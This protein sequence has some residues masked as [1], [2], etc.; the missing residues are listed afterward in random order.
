MAGKYQAAAPHIALAAASH[1][2]DT[3]GARVLLAQ[4]GIIQSFIKFINLRYISPIPFTLLN[5][6]GF[7]TI[8]TIFSLIRREATNVFKLP[9]NC[10]IP[11]VRK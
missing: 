6:L 3:R 8:L 11:F 1:A 9:N 7:I 2:P 10:K 5:F 4:V